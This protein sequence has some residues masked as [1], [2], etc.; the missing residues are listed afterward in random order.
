MKDSVVK[1]R[2]TEG[3]Y[4]G[5]WGLGAGSGDS[6]FQ[7]YDMRRLGGGSGDGPTTSE[8]V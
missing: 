8:C 2:E 1:I 5:A 6:A 7:F 3:A 4:V